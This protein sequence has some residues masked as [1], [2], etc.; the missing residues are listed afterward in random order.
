MNI[1][2]FLK[3]LSKEEREQLAEEIDASAAYIRKLAST[4]TNCSIR[5]LNS[6]YNSRF[7]KSLHEDLQFSEADYLQSR[8]EHSKTTG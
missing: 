4:S 8:K 1:N 7:N 6:I 3:T 2:Q 5:M